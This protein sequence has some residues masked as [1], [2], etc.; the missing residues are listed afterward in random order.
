[1][2]AGSLSPRA[3]YDLGISRR[4]F[5]RGCALS[6]IALAAGLSTRRAAALA[7]AQI[8]FALGVASGDPAHD[9]VVLWTRLAM[10]PLNGG[11][12]PPAP[13][14]VKWR[15]A[16]DGQMRHLVRQGTVVALPEDGH[17]VHVRVHGLAPDRWYWYQF[18]TGQEQSPVGRT[19]T[20]PAPSSHSRRLRFAFV[21]C[22]HWESGFYTAWQHL[23]QEDIDFV[24]HL[25]DYIYEDGTSAS[26]VRQHVPVSEVMTLDD[27]R[28]RYAQYRSDENLQAA[29]AQFPFIVTWDDHE[30]ENDYAGNVSE[31][32]DDADPANDVAAAEFEARRARAYKAYFEHMPLDP[33]HR[34]SGASL[35]LFRSFRWGLLAQFH[36]LDTRQFRSNQPCGGAKDL[37]LPT[38]DDLVIP[39]GEELNPNTS[40][41]GDAQQEWLLDGL[42]NSHA[43]WNVIAQ[44]VMMAAVDFGPGA[45]LFDSRLA[46]LQVRNVDAWDGYVAARNR[47]LGAI[48]EE[49]IKNL[50]VLT[51]DM[52]SSWVADLKTDFTDPASSRVGTEL[53]GPSISS[54]FPAE[55]VPIVEAALLDPANAHIKFFDGSSHGYVRCV[56]TPEQW[57]SDY[58]VVDNVLFPSAAVRTLQSFT[59]RAGLPGSLVA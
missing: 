32:N 6:A 56:V 43:R 51:G 15:V 41:T 2:Q 14:E 5:L 40:M 45:A 42:R 52:H 34:T 39:C 9:S 44:Q 29:H 18:E 31:D 26:W 11:G 46:G 3:P 21:S 54:G 23:A 37:L 8:P 1:M 17:S 38:G 10:E 12:M 13:V 58:R 24:V 35:P 28:N 36:L 57:R 25:G 49:A 50:I 48:H 27:Y 30:V 19:R 53:V 22:Q 47:L 4:V 20:L 59:V 33:R 55:F 7:P 16:T